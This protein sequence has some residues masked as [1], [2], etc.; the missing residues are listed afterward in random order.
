MAAKSRIEAAIHQAAHDAKEPHTAEPDGKPRSVRVAI[1]DPQA[2]LGTFLAILD[3]QGL[4]GDDGRLKSDVALVSIG[5]H[6]DYGPPGWRRFATEEAL[7]LLAWLAAHP[8]DQVTLILGNHDL[9]RVTELAGFD[10]STYE[11]ARQDADR[12]YNLGHR[13]E[14]LQAAFLAH[15]P[16]FADSELVARD[17]SSF[18]VRQRGLVTMLLRS[19]RF[20]LAKSINERTLLVHAGVTKEDLDLIGAPH[21]SA[22]KIADAL[23]WFLDVAVK[24]WSSGALNLMPLHKPGSQ[25]TGE[26]RGILSHR[27]AHPSLTTPAQREGPP[28]RRFDP[29]DLPEGL[30]QV[31]GHIRDGKCRETLGEWADQSPAADGPIRQLTVDGSNV[32]YARGCSKDAALLFIDGGMSHANV[33]D[34][35]LLDLEL[36]QPRMKLAISGT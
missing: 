28:R 10:Q 22:P 31:I 4:L 20:R 3:A 2:P 32:R 7:Q 34:Y 30:T 14:P 27:P 26:A 16:Q 13:I 21:A 29:R 18:S 12:A 35:Q 8:S 15:W 33:A 36:L 25:A 17:Y 23:N 11:R 19:G 5:D 9:A 1:G 24:K 6:F